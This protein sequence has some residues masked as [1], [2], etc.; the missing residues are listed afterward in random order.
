MGEWRPKAG[1]RWG[2]GVK[3]SGPRF[4]VFL[5]VVDGCSLGKPLGTL[6]ATDHGPHKQR[7]QGQHEVE[8]WMLHLPRVKPETDPGS[9]GLWCVL[10]DT[11]SQSEKTD[12]EYIHVSCLCKSFKYTN[13]H[14]GY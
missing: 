5:E 12:N 1:V 3:G 7:P 6:E 2:W 9:R 10:Q 8:G 4:L 14:A 11:K 13:S